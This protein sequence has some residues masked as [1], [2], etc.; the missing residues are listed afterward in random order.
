MK[1]NSPTQKPMP[2]EIVG[3]NKFGRYPKISAEQTFNMIISDGYLVP[4]AGYK[5]VLTINNKG[6]GRGIY[7]STRAKR[8]ILVIDNNVYSVNATT[9][10]NKVGTP[11]TFYVQILV[12]RIG[13]FSGD[14][15]IDENN[16]NQIAICD[17]QHLYIY[18]HVTGDFSRAVLPPGVF[19]S[20]VT[21]QN[22]CF[23]ITNSANNTWF[24]SSLG[25]GTN[26][27][28]NDGEASSGAIQT[29]PD[30]ASAVLR[31]PGRGNLLFVQGT[32][33]TELWSNVATQQLFPYQRNSSINIDYGIVNQATLASND[34][35][36]AW[37]G[38]NE[39]SGPV[40]MY[41]MGGDIK[42]LANDGINF[43]LSNL[44]NP[45][46][47]SAFFF[48]Q[49]G[50]IFYQITFYD[51]RDNLTLTCD[52]SNNFYFY[53]MTDQNMN[54]HIAKRV[55][56]FNDQYFF[57]SFID[58][59]LYELNS[60][61]TTYDY[62]VGANDE[63]FNC[64]IPRIR[65]CKSFS[66]PDR[67]RFVTNNLNFVVEQGDDPESQ[68]L[69]SP[70]YTPRIDLTVSKDGGETFSNGGK[71]ELNRVGIRKNRVNFWGQGSSNEFIPQFRFWG[72]S[73]YVVGNG[74]MS[75]Y[76]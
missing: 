28:P 24:L 1:P 63:P 35:Y 38:A 73:R 55:A 74:T 10:Y 39:T 52:F 17:K 56:L 19:P 37:L 53:T 69:L 31:V 67:S 34:N 4:Y 36:V 58:G 42:Q 32:V 57:V 44:S 40:I 5:N 70:N 54:F 9:S 59:N 13:T 61:F 76:Q 51:P 23:I 60:L 29:K 25:D 21:Y 30:L 22:G 8:L 48:K 33:V 45:S 72:M 20:Y 7:A 71:K 65:V 66:M 75:I 3:S 46:A 11:T 41:S 2:L 62:G 26:W 12:G 68:G 18:N 43:R 49:D 64:E 50:H 16:T 27:F 15:F 14:V 6:T 47:S